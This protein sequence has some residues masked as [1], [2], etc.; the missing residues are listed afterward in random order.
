MS[1]NRRLTGAALVLAAGLL[2]TGR[3]SAGPLLDWLCHDDCPRPSYSP[4]RYW[5]PGAAYVHDCVHGPWLS[6]Y[7]PDRHPEIPPSF[8]IL[9]YPCPAADAA[10]T[11]IPVPTPPPESRSR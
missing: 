1:R 3:A 10:S 5:T 6:V 9:K 8:N 7:P 2:F 11:L 4:F